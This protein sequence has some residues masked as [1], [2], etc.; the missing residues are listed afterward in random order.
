MSESKLVR[1]YMAKGEIEAQVIKALLEDFGIPSMFQSQS[2]QSVYTFA[3]DGMGQVSILVRAED[4]A[5][6]REL[7]K[8]E[9]NA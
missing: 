5:A 2:T 9:K 4:E 8:G 7:I 6:A 1:V 3:V